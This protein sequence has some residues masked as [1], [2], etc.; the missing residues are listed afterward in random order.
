MFID[1]FPGIPDLLFNVL[2]VWFGQDT[3][4]H[5]IKSDEIYAM[6]KCLSIFKN[7]FDGYLT[8]IFGSFSRIIL[9]MIR[10]RK[11]K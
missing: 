11:R 1:F 3:G 5:I 10:T 8:D 6:R 7:Y 9:K 2:H 4:L